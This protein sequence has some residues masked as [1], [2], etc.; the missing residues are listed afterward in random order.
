MAANA[1]RDDV[2]DL[3]RVRLS[4]YRLHAHDERR[5]TVSTVLLILLR[6]DI[7]ARFRGLF[8]V[9]YLQYRVVRAP[10]RRVRVPVLSALETARGRTLRAWGQLV[11]RDTATRVA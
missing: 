4:L 1:R 8:V 2:G 10:W 7:Q 11:D 9:G 3:Y 5:D 6:R